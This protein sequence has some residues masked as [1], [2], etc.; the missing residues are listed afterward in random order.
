[1]SNDPE[2][3]TLLHDGHLVAAHMK[4]LLQKRC[5]IAG[6]EILRMDFFDIAY[7]TE[8]AAQLLQVQ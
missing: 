1:M 2:E 6:V 8:I 4:K 7:H 5:E 3:I